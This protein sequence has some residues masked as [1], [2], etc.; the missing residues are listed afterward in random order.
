MK[1][2]IRKPITVLY[3]GN[4]ED[5]ATLVGLANL[6]AP[7]KLIAFT[8]DLTNEHGAY[9]DELNAWLNAKGLPSV[10]IHPSMTVDEFNRIVESPLKEW[11]WQRSEC[12][13]AIRLAGLSIPPATA[14]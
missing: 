8:G 11:G 1:Y 14:A 7:V 13:A 12:E 10:T 9:L 3:R 2:K 6:S 5:T 4:L